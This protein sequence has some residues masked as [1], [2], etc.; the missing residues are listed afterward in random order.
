MG[1][2]ESIG[3]HATKDPSSFRDPSGF[4]FF[5]K[6]ILYR[7][8]NKI[9]SNNYDLLMQSGLYSELIRKNYLIPHKEVPN[10]NPN[11]DCYKTIQPEKIDFISYPY[12]WSFSELKDAALLT[13]K[14]QKIALR[15]NMTLKDSSAYNIQFKNGNPILIDTLS[16]EKYE[17][18]YPWVA[19]RQFCQHFLA[20]LALMCLKD[21]RLNQLL[22]IYIDGIPL[23]LAS[24]LL[25]NK[26]WL[27]PVTFFHIHMHAKSQK[28]FSE[29]KVNF[30]KRKFGRFSF[31]NLINSLKDG[32]SSLRWEAGKTEWANYYENTNYSK[33][34]INHKSELVSKFIISIKPKSVWDLG[35][36]DGLFSRLSSSREI[37]TIAFDI[38]PTSVE[39][40][41]LTIKKEKEKNLLPLVSDLTNP[42]PSL[43]WSSQ[44][45]KSLIKRGPADLGLALALIHHLTISNNVPF[46]ASASFFS[47]VCKTLI[48][49]FVPKDD[50]QVERLLKN[51]T[52]IFGSYTQENFEKE[53]GRYFTVSD[54]YQIL[55]SKRVLY[56]MRRV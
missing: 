36:N 50:S 20:P 34:S 26:S 22:K 27:K 23:D 38:D 17:E 51:R 21:I 6:G 2:K 46:E 11:P 29:K 33:S 28:H 41:Y 43:G 10:F 25:P 12:E 15:F 54:S 45:R 49:E 3:E 9:Y 55:A 37:E 40:N 8:V 39:K 30:N 31:I 7:Q 35:A 1:K 53:F 47:K 48:I 4:I 44:E 52:D 24:V 18:G 56:L 19:Y 13:L 42:S 32:V 16:F 14:I 5:E